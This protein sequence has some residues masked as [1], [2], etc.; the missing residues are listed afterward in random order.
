MPV[1]YLMNV[2][3]NNLILPLHVLWYSFGT[4]CG[5]VA[6]QGK[7]IAADVC[8]ILTQKIHNTTKLS[9]YIPNRSNPTS[10]ITKLLLNFRWREFYLKPKYLLLFK[11]AGDGWLCNIILLRL[12]IHKIFLRTGDGGMET[13]QS[14]ERSEGIVMIRIWRTLW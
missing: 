3:K 1:K 6:L 5:H 11:A 2:S 14:V 4:H 9:C 7:E 13:D 12:I 10:H 8:F